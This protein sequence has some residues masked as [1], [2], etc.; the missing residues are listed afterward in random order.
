MIEPRALLLLG[1]G[2]GMLPM[3]MKSVLRTPLATV[4]GIPDAWRGATLFSGAIGELA[5]WIL[6]D[7]PGRA[8]EGASI[9]EGEPAWTRGFPCW[10]A[11][12]SGA[13]VCVHVSAG[14]ALVDEPHP[15]DRAAIEPGTLA[16]VSDHMNVSGRTPLVGLGASKLGPLFPAASTLHHAELRAAALALGLE[17]GLP[18]AEAVLACAPGPALETAAERRWWR[19]AGADVAAQGVAEPLLA[20]AHAGLGTLAI[21]CVTDRGEAASDVAA[22]LA[23]A[24]SLAAGLDEL[25]ARLAPALARAAGGLDAGP[26]TDGDELADVDE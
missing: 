24:E 20:A 14:L 11:A 12:A 5:A 22:I 13:N 3:R 21:V 4:D 18:V 19:R 8:E 23:R 15:R 25:L 1:T 2:V 9:P 6:E 17:L 26:A 16:L 7:A 10:L